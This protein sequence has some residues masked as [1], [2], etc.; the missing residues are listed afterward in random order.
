MESRKL[1]AR[2]QGNREFLFIEGGVSVLQD[3]KGFWRWMDGDYGCRA[4]TCISCQM[5]TSKMVKVAKIKNTNKNE[6][7]KI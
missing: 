1:V 7:E 3:D 6:N 5:Y 4:V 2:G